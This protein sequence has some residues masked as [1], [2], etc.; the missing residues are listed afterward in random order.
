MGKS[1]FLGLR[2]REIRVSTISFTHHISHLFNRFLPSLAINRHYLR[3]LHHQAFIKG[4]GKLS[5]KHDTVPTCL[6]HVVL[7]KPERPKVEAQWLWLRAKYVLFQI[8]HRVHFF[9]SPVDCFFSVFCVEYVS[10][11][12]LHTSI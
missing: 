12:L 8:G 10:Q 3:K 11:Q 7:I 2:P 1:L 5:T 4:R 9:C 6:A